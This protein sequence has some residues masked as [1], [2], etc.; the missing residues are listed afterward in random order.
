M[1][2]FCPKL[3]FLKNVIVGLGPTI[4]LRPFRSQKKNPDSRLRGNY[5]V[6]VIF[7]IL[8]FLA[9]GGCRYNYNRMKLINYADPGRPEE[10]YQN[11]SGGAF[12]Q[13]SASEYEILLSSS[14]P[15]NQDG[16][17]ILKQTVFVTTIWRAIPGKT[18]A[19]SSQINARLVYLVEI[20]EPPQSQVKTEGGKIVLRYKGSGF[21]SYQTDRSGNV[22]TGR[23]EQALMQPVGNKAKYRLDNFEL[24]G[25]FK[26][27]KNQAAIAEFKFINL[28]AFR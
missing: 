21:V 15:M 8:L 20:A 23:I 22:L 18:Y 10:L 16:N 4:Q 25:N 11:F 9:G 28:S 2:F 7:I 13:K 3:I 24:S 12:S 19:E 14:E 27:S 6:S 26:A 1:R 5:R 17:E